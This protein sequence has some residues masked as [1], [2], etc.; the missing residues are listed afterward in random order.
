M[1]LIRIFFILL[2]V[3][4]APLFAAVTSVTINPE[5]NDADS[6]CT[7]TLPDKKFYLRIITDDSASREKSGIVGETRM[8]RK[9]MVP[10]VCS[11]SPSV[12]LRSS[13]VDFLTKKSILAPSEDAADY[14]IDI[15]IQSFTLA[16]TYKTFT[17][18]MRGIVA[19]QVTI[20]GRD[21]AQTPV[22]FSVSTQN[23]YTTMDTSKHAERVLQGALRDAI[24]EIVKN[25]ATL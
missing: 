11:P 17:Q 1:P 2:L 16:E 19:V 23:S 6:L 20:A 22:K 9:T 10:I 21:G 14:L 25:F 15:V 12:I 4:T 24:L 3:S 7:V 8:R 13:I 18:T 5:V